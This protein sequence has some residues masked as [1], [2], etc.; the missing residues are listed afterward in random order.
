ME[1]RRH[2]LGQVG[3]NVVPGLR[4]AGWRQVVLDGFHGRNSIS[5]EG[6][7]AV[8]ARKLKERPFDAVV[9]SEQTLA[10][11]TFKMKVREEATRSLQ[12]LVGFH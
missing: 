9:Q 3:G 11:D 12:R 5:D 6:R 1:R 7:L 10:R 4:D 2:G 8:T